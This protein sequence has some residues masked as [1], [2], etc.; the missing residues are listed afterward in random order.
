MKKTK[1]VPH[2]LEDNIRRAAKRWLTAFM[3]LC[4]ICLF[5]YAK[6]SQH[7][8]KISHYS[9]LDFPSDIKTD[10][11]VQLANFTHTVYNQYQLN[12][13]LYYPSSHHDEPFDIM[14]GYGKMA[15]AFPPEYLKHSRPPKRTPP[16][17]PIEELHRQHTITTT[18]SPDQYQS[19]D[20]VMKGMLSPGGEINMSQSDDSDETIQFI[21]T[22]YSN[23]EDLELEQINW[24]QYGNVQ[25]QVKRMVLEQT[26]NVTSCLVYRLDIRFPRS[27]HHFKQFTARVDHA[28]R[29]SGHLEH[30]E[31][32]KFQI[33]LGRGAI[34]FDNLRANEI[35]M[36]SLKGIILG[37]YYPEKKFSSSVLKGATNVKL[38]PQSKALDAVIVTVDGPVTT[39]IKETDAYNRGGF[40]LHCWVKSN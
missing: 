27:M 6:Y 8:K 24:K 33:G 17:C 12:K 20:V 1:V 18:F 19:L 2:S 22:L 28:Q 29:I 15:I 3:V 26:L 5:L 39:S 40:I 36:S 32:Q 25:T 35:I 38:F 34:Q 37:D 9:I 4:G 31:F 16:V 13:K 7:F 21:L 23:Q 30:V 10:D 14:E 11:T